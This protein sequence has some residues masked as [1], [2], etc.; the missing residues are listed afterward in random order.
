MP[1]LSPVGTIGY[2]PVSA[3]G[4]TLTMHCYVSGQSG[5]AGATSF[6]AVLPFR[7]WVL[8]ELNQRLCFLVCEPQNQVID[9]GIAGKWIVFVRRQRLHFRRSFDGDLVG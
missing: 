4:E 5:L 3:H 2:C 8:V 9:V 1:T 7:H 6:F